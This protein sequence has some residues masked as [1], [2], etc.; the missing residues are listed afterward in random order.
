MATWEDVERVAA[1]LP[2]TTLKAPRQW[3]VHRRLFVWERPLR[4]RDLAELA[5]DAPDD[6]P[7]AFHVSDDGEKQA[8]LA[9]DPRTFFT[10]SHFD[11]YAIVLARLDRVA[12]PELEELV[13]DA[14]LARA[15][16]RLAA[17]F[18]DA[19]E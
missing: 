10:T 18:L 13:Q 6:A 7:V 5:D 16:R 8:L 1:V 3:T 17:R 15:P 19:S 4:A 9:D 14:W 2:D 12:V 11:G